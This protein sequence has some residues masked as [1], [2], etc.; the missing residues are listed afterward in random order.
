MSAE[1]PVRQTIKLVAAV[2]IRNGDIF[3][4]ARRG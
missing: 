1:R 3:V 2:V 4:A